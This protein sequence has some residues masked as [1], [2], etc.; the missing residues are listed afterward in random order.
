MEGEEIPAGGT[1]PSGGNVGRAGDEV[2]G[3]N[4]G[5]SCG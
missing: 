1:L 4:G 5:A 3:S 2:G